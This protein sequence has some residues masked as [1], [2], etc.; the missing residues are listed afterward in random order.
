MTTDKQ[1]PIDEAEWQAQEQA[2]RSQD[3]SVLASALASHRIGEPPVD[4][5][6]SVVANVAQHESAAERRT[7][8]LLL[9]TFAVVIGM[10]IAFYGASCWQ[11]LNSLPGDHARGWVVIGVACLVLS[12]VPRLLRPVTP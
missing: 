7:V 2:L 5:A 6:A 4:F 1:L 3:N 12:W 10:A 11:A 8:R 9:A